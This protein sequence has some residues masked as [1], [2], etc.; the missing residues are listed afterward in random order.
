MDKTAWL[1]LLLA[2]FFAIGC[3]RAHGR[4]EPGRKMRFLDFFRMTGRLERLRRSR[5]QWFSIVAIMLVLRLQH[6]LP[7]AVE[8]MA[9]MMF[10]IFLVIP[11]EELV[12]VR[13]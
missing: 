11:V 7:P 1:E 4:F 8:I 2:G 12:R 13:R 6:Q 9:G 10:L 3:I 5:W